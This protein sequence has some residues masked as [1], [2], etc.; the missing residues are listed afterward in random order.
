MA[1]LKGF[2]NPAEAQLPSESGAGDLPS[3]EVSWDS[4]RGRR[5]ASP[6]AAAQEL[7]CPHPRTHITQR[8]RRKPPE[9][10]AGGQGRGEKEQ[11]AFELENHFK[12][13]ISRSLRPATVVPGTGSLPR[14]RGVSPP[15]AAF[16]SSQW[17]RAQ[18][19]AGAEVLGGW[20]WQP[21]A[22]NPVVT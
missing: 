1:L 21:M 18:D 5:P 11:L 13:E 6:S 10:C 15:E 4:P 2:S 3:L 20:G 22:P 7:S 12:K 8:G 19:R 14:A 9:V 16:S 17:V